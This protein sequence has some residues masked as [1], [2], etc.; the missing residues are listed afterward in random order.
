MAVGLSHFLMVSGLLFVLGIISMI[1]RRNMIGVLLGIELIMNAAG[2]NFI[3]FSRY[4]AQDLSGH[5]FTLFIL[6]IA[7]SEAVVALAI[8]LRIYQNRATISVEAVGEM[9]C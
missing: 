7:A 1:S 9:K 6:I 4:I 5:I 8:V 2:L 3:A